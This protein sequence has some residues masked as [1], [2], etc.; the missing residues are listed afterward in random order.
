MIQNAN[1]LVIK[2]EQVWGELDDDLAFRIVGF[3]IIIGTTYVV[4]YD[5]EKWE[6]DRARPEDPRF[7]T[8]RQ[9][10]DGAPVHDLAENERFWVEGSES[11]HWDEMADVKVW[12]GVD[13]QDFNG[14]GFI[15]A[16]TY[17]YTYVEPK[18]KQRIDDETC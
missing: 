7:I 2:P 8:L 6:Y 1:G 10:H 12:D 5:I 9:G 4:F 17:K 13:W 18:E 16:S 3:D 11:C 14:A 15:H